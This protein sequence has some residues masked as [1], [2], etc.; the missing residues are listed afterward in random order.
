EYTPKP[1]SYIRPVFHNITNVHET[2]V[3]WFG[4]RGISP[5]TVKKFN[6]TQD[7]KYFPQVSENRSCINF[8][9]FR[10]SELINVKYRDHE[11]NFMLHK[12]SELIFYNLDSIKESSFAI[13]VEGECDAMIVDQIGLENVVSVPNGATLSKNPNLEYLENC[14]DYFES[15][16]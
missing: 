7:T 3:H 14:Y 15:K 13:I 1:K 8:N 16:E 12:D 11:K 5:I 4:K 6:I 10:D 9:Y 2:I